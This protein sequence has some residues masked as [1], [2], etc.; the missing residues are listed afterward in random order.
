MFLVFVRNVNDPLSGTLETVDPPRLRSEFRPSA[1]LINACCLR[2][3]LGDY[4]PA[5][6]SGQLLDHWTGEMNGEESRPDKNDEPAEEA[7]KF[8]EVFHA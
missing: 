4:S 2:S 1:G 7:K 6:S 8:D 3:V 5:R